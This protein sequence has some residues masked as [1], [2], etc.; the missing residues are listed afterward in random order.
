MSSSASDLLGRYLEFCHKSCALNEA[1]SATRAIETAFPN[2]AEQEPALLLNDLQ[3]FLLQ[4]IAFDGFITG[5]LHAL[6]MRKEKDLPIRGR[7][8]SLAD[9]RLRKDRG[10]HRTLTKVE[11]IFLVRDAWLHGQGDPAVT[12]R[13]QWP[14]HFNRQFGIAHR[15]NRFW[16][17]LAKK[18]PDGSPV[19]S[20][21]VGTLKGVARAVWPSV[22]Q[23]AR[24]AADRLELLLPDTS[25]LE[26]GP[27]K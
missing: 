3:L 18:G 17:R 21:L 22:Q 13:S 1:L 7:V 26:D 12:K 19:W 4:V 23:H 24:D 9:D 25:Q 27:G 8:M 16:I 6:S 10:F 11:E 15:D 5:C 14:G 20:F 2:P